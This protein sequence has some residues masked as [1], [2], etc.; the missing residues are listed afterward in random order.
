VIVFQSLTLFALRSAHFWQSVCPK[1]ATNQ[2]E[3]DRFHHSPGAGGGHDWILG[4]HDPP[5]RASRRVRRVYAARAEGR[6]GNRETKFRGVVEKQTR[7]LKQQK[8]KHMDTIDIILLAIVF[9]SSAA[10]LAFASYDYGLKAGINRERSLS[11]KRVQGVLAGMK[12]A[13][14]LTKVALKNRRARK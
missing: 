9:A 12:N 11:D 13:P 7:L 5:V 1:T 8:I 2:N 4:L 14:K 6:M 3:H 10:L